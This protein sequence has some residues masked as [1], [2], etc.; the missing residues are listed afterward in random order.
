MAPTESLIKEEWAAIASKYRYKIDAEEAIKDKLVK[1]VQT[2]I[3]LY[4]TQ[5]LTDNNL[6][7]VFQ[8][9]FKGFTVKSFKKIYTDIRSKLQK[10]LLKRGVFV[11]KYCNK[12]IISKLL[13]EV[14]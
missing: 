4:K 10:Y 1:F 5:D 3:Y 13:F 9:Q 14:I 11:G 8:K 6:Q 7:A 2:V 12:V